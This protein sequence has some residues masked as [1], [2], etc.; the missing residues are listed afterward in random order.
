MSKQFVTL[1]LLLISFTVLAVA[2]GTTKLRTPVPPSVEQIR[3]AIKVLGEAIRARDAEEMSEFEAKLKKA[4]GFLKSKQAQK[5]FHAQILCGKE[6]AFVDEQDC[7]EQGGLKEST[8]YKG[9]PAEALKLINAALS[10]DHWNWD[11]TWIEAAR[12]EGKKLVVVLIDG[13]A[14]NKDEIEIPEC[15]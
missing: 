5:T 1:G 14:E 10:A 7:Y 3:T 6:Q 11:E 4:Q 2:V 8:C 15:K 9:T 12:I 13:Q